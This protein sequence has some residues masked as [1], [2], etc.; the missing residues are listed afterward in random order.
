M[1]ISLIIVL[2]LAS[3]ALAGQLAFPVE[4]QS[5]DNGMTVFLIPDHSC[6]SITVQVWYKAGSRNERPGITGI[7]HLF[8]HLM[9]KGTEKYPGGT[10]DRL[11]ESNGGWDNA[12]TWLDNT[13]Y[14]EVMPSD[15]LEL[16]LEL[17]ADRNRNLTLDEENVDSERNVVINERLWGVDNSPE[18]SMYEVL[19]NNAFVSHPYRWEVV[20]FLDDLRAITLEDCLEYYRVHYAPNNSFLI[21]S[22]DFD[23][24]KT[25]KL[26]KKYFGPLKAEEPPPPV[27]SIE[28]EQKGEKRIDFLR[29]AQLPAM[30]AG[31]KIPG[32]AHADI[33][34]LEVAAKILFD[35][36]SSRLQKRLVYQ[37]QKAV[38]I[39]GEAEAHHDPYLFYVSAQAT[40]GSDIEDIKSIVF[41]E[42]AKLTSE[43]VS[44]DEL[45]KAKNQMESDFI[46]GLQS[47]TNRAFNIGI[48][49]INTDDYSN[50]YEYP[51]NIQKVT[52]DDVMRVAAEYLVK[53]RRTVVT[54]IP[55]EAQETADVTADE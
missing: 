39:D 18:G 4:K 33:T 2:V 43:P 52:A 11:V 40:P 13:A 7:S 49:E 6:P 24:P 22:G 41:E 42:I 28:P 55:E 31:Y 1:K 17:E 37:E 47:N 36:E 5:L 50:I 44:P 35:G 34:P 3:T 46:M 20:G 8:E 23:P 12:W 27:K 25:M 51:D 9:F 21:I 54:L 38:S 19:I 29:A 32:A 53:N 30:I 26:V 15:K 48:F 16:V 45:Q 10:F 14:Y